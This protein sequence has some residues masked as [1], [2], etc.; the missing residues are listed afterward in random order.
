[1]TNPTRE[2]LIAA[3]PYFD[4]DNLVYDGRTFPKKGHVAKPKWPES[5]RDEA[6]FLN[7]IA[8]LEVARD[9]LKERDEGYRANRMAV[10][11]LDGIIE[12]ARS[13]D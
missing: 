8:V 7:A 10:H 4:R 5:A 3:Q 12:E 11:L 9:I 6:K 2:R 13:D 1:M